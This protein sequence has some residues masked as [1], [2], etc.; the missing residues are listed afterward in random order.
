MQISKERAKGLF[1]FNSSLESVVQW[2]LTTWL[3]ENVIVLAA[4]FPASFDCSRE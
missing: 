3:Y 1:K 2:H 4:V